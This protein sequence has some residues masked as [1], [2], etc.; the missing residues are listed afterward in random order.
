MGWMKEKYTKK[1]FLD[2]KGDGNKLGYGVHGIE[3]WLEGKIAPRCKIVLDK[4]KI[5]GT[6]STKS[7]LYK[8]ILDG[9]NV[10]GLI[11]GA[12]DKVKES[13]IR[14]WVSR[15]KKGNAIPAGFVS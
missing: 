15:W 4:I 12:K 11:E 7:I 10:D 5:K 1:Y 3:Y 9:S 14:V 6:V 2:G 8:L 13:T